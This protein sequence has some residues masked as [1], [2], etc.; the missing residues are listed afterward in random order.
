M[1]LVCFLYHRPES[2]VHSPIFQNSQ[3]LYWHSWTFNLSPPRGDC[4]LTGSGLALHFGAHFIIFSSSR[5]I[6]RKFTWEQTTSSA[7]CRETSVRVI[8]GVLRKSKIATS[9]LVMVWPISRWTLTKSWKI[10]L[11]IVVYV[12]SSAVFTQRCWLSLTNLNVLFYWHL[13]PLFT[14]S[15]HS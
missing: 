5:P 12:F 2:W 1:S 9:Q 4:L 8:E 6:R 3:T 11:L 15:K 10:W 14:C 13:S 7:D